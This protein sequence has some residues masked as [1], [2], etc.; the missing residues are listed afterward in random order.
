M[1]LTIKFI[2]CLLIALNIIFFMNIN[3]L[4]I[5]IV[6]NMCIFKN[7]NQ[8]TLDKISKNLPTIAVG[9]NFLI[10]FLTIFI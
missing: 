4:N 6:D 2:I 8:N 7:I 10:L 3:E 1:I 5:S 9:I